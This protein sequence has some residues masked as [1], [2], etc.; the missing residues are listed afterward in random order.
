MGKFSEGYCISLLSCCNKKTSNKMAET[1]EIYC[2]I[3]LEPVCPR[4]QSWGD[5]SLLKVM[6]KSLFHV[7]LLVL[8]WQSFV[9]HDM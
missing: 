3:V 9:V 4:S 8:F 2:L 1:T 7:L 6:G 5:W